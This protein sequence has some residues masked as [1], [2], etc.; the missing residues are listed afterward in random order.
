MALLCAT[1]ASWPVWVGSSGSPKMLSPVK[2]TWRPSI[3]PCRQRANSVWPGHPVDR[4]LVAFPLER[5]AGFESA[6][7]AH[8]V[9]PRA[10]GSLLAVGLDGRGIVE[11]L[12]VLHLVDHAVEGPDLRAPFLPQV[13]RFQEMVAMHVRDDDG[14]DGF[15]AEVLAQFPARAV[16][17]ELLV[18][19]AAIH[20]Q[21]AAAV[22]EDQPEIRPEV[23][24]A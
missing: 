4:E 20:H 6:I 1:M 3:W 8:T 10:V 22:G 9:H 7:D 17:E 14:V 16:V 23:L 5:L 18:Q 15:Q 19:Q 24:A 2:A 21:S 11:A 13:R 12:R